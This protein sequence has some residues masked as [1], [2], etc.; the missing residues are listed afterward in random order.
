M[1][2]RGFTI[3]E[4]V[5]VVTIMAILLVLGVVN[6]RSAQASARDDERRTDIENLSLHLE[7][8]YRSGIEGSAN[9][10]R[11][12]S[13]GL[14]DY[15]ASF[16]TENL[17][18]LDLKSVM[19]PGVTDPLVTLKM[20]NNN[21]QT[22]AGVSPQPSTSEYI[23]QSLQQDGTLCTETLQMCSKFNLYYRLEVAAISPDCPAPGFVCMVT[24]KNQ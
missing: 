17:R 19:A 16:I 9:T 21:T 12:P 24:S 8:F 6:L 10:G 11:Y 7:I 5:I 18:D 20:A 2:R 4:L 14:V 3:V 15:G 23:Y 1:Y 13:D 22:T